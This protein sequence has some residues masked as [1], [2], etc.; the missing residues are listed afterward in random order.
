MKLLISSGIMSA[1]KG[2]IPAVV[3]QEGYFNPEM[4]RWTNSSYTGKDTENFVDD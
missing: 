3:V 1:K 4:F 2:W